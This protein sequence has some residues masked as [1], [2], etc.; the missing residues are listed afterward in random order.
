MI[1]GRIVVAVGSG[2]YDCHE[3]LE[4]GCGTVPGVYASLEFERILATIG[5]T[6][7]QSRGHD[8]EAPPRS[9]SCAAWAASP[10]TCL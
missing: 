7:S 8:G 3:L 5:P 6:S 4:L 9:Q 10:R 2:L 1:Q